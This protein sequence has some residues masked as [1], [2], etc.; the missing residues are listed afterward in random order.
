MRKL[1]AFGIASAMLAGCVQTTG[2][3]T[4]RALCEVWG[5]GL[6]LPSRA[7]TADTVTGLNDQVRD[8]R[9]ACPGF[10]SP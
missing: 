5:E 1:I 6:F 7:D 8:Y 3:A 9:A 4:E 2:S 10:P